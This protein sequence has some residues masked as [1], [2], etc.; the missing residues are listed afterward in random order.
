MSES[1]I[2]S[3]KTVLL[4]VG[5]SLLKLPD[6]ADRL[7]ALIDNHGLQNVLVLVGGGEAADLVRCW[8]RRFHLSDDA[9]HVL[10]VRAMSLNAC[11][12]ST[13]H[14]RFEL[15]GTVPPPQSAKTPSQNARIAVL[16][17][18]LVLAALEAEHPPLARSWNVTSDSIAAWIAA[19]CRLPQLWLIKSIDLPIDLL[20]SHASAQITKS[21]QATTLSNQTLVDSA[22]PQYSR[23][24]A[25]VSW[26]NLNCLAPAV[27]RIW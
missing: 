19:C 4:K 1:S 5:G 6:V 7:L 10:A 17:A 21:S 26:C 3:G 20:T 9:A 14:K 22:F 18:A 27:F 13:Q 15:T 23:G 11:L 24:V 16:D 25:H 12:L 8:D 2:D